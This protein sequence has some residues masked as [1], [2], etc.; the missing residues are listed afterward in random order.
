M[1]TTAAT[2]VSGATLIFLACGASFAAE[3]SNDP[4]RITNMQT[5]KELN[6]DYKVRLKY[7]LYLPKDYESKKAWPLVLFLH[8]AGERGDNL[9]LVKKHGPPKLVAEGKEFPFVLVSPQCLAGRWWEPVELSALLDE[10]EEKHKIDKDRVYV[11]G[12]SMGGFG[13]WTLEAYAPKRFAAIVPIC[14]GG[15]PIIVKLVPQVPTWVFHGAKDPAVPVA[16]SEDMVKA[17]KAAGATVKF[18]VYP[19][20][21]H[22]SWTQAYND[23]KLYEWL[24]AQKRLPD[25]KP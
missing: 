9:D 4:T 14:G 8:G 21:F 25:K 19:D 15:E 23:P 10:V 24:L 2:V 16:R 22:D 20:A 5:A 7:L 17:L 1:K 11:T 18:T 12:L 6:R 13:T 3:S